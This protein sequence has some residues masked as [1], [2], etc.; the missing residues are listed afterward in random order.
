M[1]IRKI[2]CVATATLFPLAI[3]LTAEA[4]TFSVHTAV[5]DDAGLLDDFQGPAT[6]GS[7][8]STSVDAGGSS[9]DFSGDAVSRAVGDEN[10]LAAVST[11]GV[12]ACGSCL[13][14]QT[15]DSLSE[16]SF[17]NTS[18]SA[19][20]FTYDFFIN[21]PLVELVDFAIVD[22]FA[23]LSSNAQ[24]SVT[25]TTSG[26]ASDSFF[27]SLL[28][29]GGL[30]HHTVDAVGGNTTFFNTA[31]GFGYKMDDLTGVFT[32]TLAVGESVTFE[33]SLLASIAGPGFEVGGIA[34]IGDPNNLAITPGVSNGF[35]VSSVPVPSPTTAWLFLVGLGLLVFVGFARGGL[36]VRRSVLFAGQSYS[37]AQR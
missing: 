10:G 20:T 6:A 26:G 30:G 14:L 27:A 4:V 23:G 19:V 13:F 28:L 25:M 9:L 12:Y 5:G 29:T 37:R 11:E 8:L 2:V 35:S 15:A 22:E 17:T 34:K 18:A 21:G 7:L 1:N 36:A 16:S 31:N 3:C 32:G 24:A 33:T